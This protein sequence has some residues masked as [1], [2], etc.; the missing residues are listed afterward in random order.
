[1]RSPSPAPSAA[2]DRSEPGA[3]LVAGDLGPAIAVRPPGPRSRELAAVLAQC[4]APGVNTV[5]A[6]PSVVWA[7]A[8]GSNVLDVD[9]NRYVDLTSGFGVAAI[10]HRHPRVVTAIAE[11]SAR[12]VHGLGD[13]AAHPAR[14]ELAQRLCALAPMPGA[15]VYFAVSGSDSV[16]IALKTAVLAT[17]R[18]DVL[19]FEPA[20]HGTSMGALALTSRQAF[21]A[22][23]AAIV[24][25]TTHRLPYGCT[26]SELEGA[27][28]RCGESLACVVFEPVVGREGV[29]FPP[30]GWL[31]SV[32]E[33]ARAHG[34]LVIADEIFTGF[35]RTGALFA[36]TAEGVVPDLVCCGKALGGGLPIAAVLGRSDLMA[37]WDR[38]GEAIHTATFLAHP[39]ACAAAIATLDVLTEESLAARA[40]TLGASIESRAGRWRA[41]GG[42]V[43][44]RG[45][46]LLWA[47]EL[48]EAR[49]AGRAVERALERGLLVLTCGAEGRTLQI[50]PPLTIRREQLEI[51]LD[52][53]EEVLDS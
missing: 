29:H 2:V 47:I 16:E 8:V 51:A 9:G 40:A 44:V 26:A 19:A 52:L 3:A 53:L 48:A 45:R 42:V 4:E 27:L 28:A 20:Y 36:S 5:S 41:L 33:R 24:A 7:Q 11:Q 13:V 23:F 35:G 37:A 14:A 32:A 50:V 30:P 10:G 1:M 25:R 49:A 15:R 12:L 34:A 22:P 38:P 43:S 46:G 21:T 31:A 17:G 18:C 6:G 39:L